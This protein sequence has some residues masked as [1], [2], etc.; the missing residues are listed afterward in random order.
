MYGF[1]GIIFFLKLLGVFRISFLIVIIF[2]CLNVPRM[3]ISEFADQICLRAR[4]VDPDLTGTGFQRQNS[5]GIFH[6]L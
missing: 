6:N 4:E 1:A 2:Q 5:D 3:T